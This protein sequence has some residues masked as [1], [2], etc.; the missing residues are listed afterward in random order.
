MPR[1]PFD[2]GRWAFALFYMPVTI[3]LGCRFQAKSPERSKNFSGLLL[4]RD[5]GKNSNMKCKPVDRTIIVL[6]RT[7]HRCFDS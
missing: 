4:G 7:V 1:S 6:T 2:V 3:F 5:R